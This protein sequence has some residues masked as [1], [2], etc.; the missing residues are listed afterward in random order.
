MEEI[1]GTLTLEREI[2]DDARK[3]AARLLSNADAE[4]ARIQAESAVKTAAA[5]GAIDEAARLATARYRGEVFARIPLEKLRMKTAHS[6]ALIREALGRWLASLPESRIES[7]V[8]KRLEGAKAFLADGSVE[9]RYRGIGAS[10]AERLAGQIGAA[11]EVVIREDNTLS[12]TGIIVS[13]KGAELDATL[14]VAADL[15]LRKK[16]GEL[17]RALAPRLAQS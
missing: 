8:V 3:K 15:I 2:M 12:A 1:A 9:I 7:F 16:R 5:L 11:G 4:S 6:D 17:I 13:G 14:D 10:C